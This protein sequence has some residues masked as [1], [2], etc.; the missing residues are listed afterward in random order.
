MPPGAA[1]GERR[2]GRAKG[3]HNKT[4]QEK[5]DEERIAAQVAAEVTGLPLPQGKL[6]SEG[7][8][9]KPL[10]KERLSELAELFLGATAFF[11]PRGPS[12]TDNVNGNWD[13]FAEFGRLAMECHYKAAQ[14]QSPT[15]KAINVSTVTPVEDKAKPGADNVINL[16]DPIA[17]AR[18]YRRIMTGKG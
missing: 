12:G 17:A 13:R 9:R 1:P 14:F 15:F 10:S 5:I 3:V 16:D 6:P 18:V 4:T 7:T 2:G 11:Q 8:T